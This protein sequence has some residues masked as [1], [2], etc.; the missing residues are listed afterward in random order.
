MSRHDDRV[1]LH[2]MLDHARTAVE[3][4]SGENRASLDSNPMLR[5]SLLHLIT[6]LGE[7]ANRVSP[8]CKTRHNQVVWKDIIGMRN[9]LIHGYDV[10][11]LD[12][13]WETVRTDLPALIY[14]L[15]EVLRE[16]HQ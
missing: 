13:L 15:Q 3:F 4:V 16:T 5:Y 6:V 9:M 10:V 8:E 1:Y 7:A 12:I 2:H 14:V 11:D